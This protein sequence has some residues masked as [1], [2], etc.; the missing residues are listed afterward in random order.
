[1]KRIYRGVRLNEYDA[2]H[3]KDNGMN[4][5]WKNPEEAIGDVFYAI[6]VHKIMKHMATNGML[7]WRIMEASHELRNQIFGSEDRTIAESYARDTPEL[8]FLTL[9]NGLVSTDKIQKY[10]NKRYGL[11][12]LVTFEIDEPSSTIP[13]INKRVG[14]FI[15]P[16]QIIEVEK[17]DMTKPDPI[18]AK[19]G[20]I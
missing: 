17:I 9:S 5:Y 19:F 18:H 1:M 3:L 2:Y 15:P 13:D 4:Y 11:P 16:E 6:K 7:E 20:M 12:H 10:L 8:I 14:K